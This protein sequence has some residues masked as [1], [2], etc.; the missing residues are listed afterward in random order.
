LLGIYLKGKTVSFNI[1]SSIP[2]IQKAEAK[3]EEKG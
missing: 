2:P 3:C 1:L